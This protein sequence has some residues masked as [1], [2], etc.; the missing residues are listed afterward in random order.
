LLLVGI[1]AGSGNLFFRCVMRRQALIDYV[2]KPRFAWSQLKNA[3]V[4]I[5]DLI[6][7]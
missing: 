5:T 1:I 4:P 6:V 2:A 3:A 7:R